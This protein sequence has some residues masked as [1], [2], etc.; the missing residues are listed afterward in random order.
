MGQGTEKNILVVE[1]D[2][3]NRAEFTCSD[4]VWNDGPGI[5]V[6]TIVAAVVIEE[7]TNAADSRLVAYVDL[8]NRLT[9]GTSYT[10]NI[11]AEGLIHLRTV[12]S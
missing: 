10:I 2:P 1:D 6:G 12:L 8:V 4:P 5:D 3:N 11:D 9:N 7:R